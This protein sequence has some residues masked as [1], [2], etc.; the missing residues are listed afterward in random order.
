MAQVGTNA[1]QTRLSLRAE[2]S[3]P[4]FE[5]RR[6]AA[7]ELHELGDNSGVPVMIVAMTNLTN[8]TERNNAVVALRITKDPRSIPIL[9]KMTSDRSAYVRSIA[10][11]ALGELAATNAFD[12]I[13]S[14]LSDLENFGGDVPRCPGDSA[15]YAL[16]ALEDKKAI[17]LLVNALDHRETQ[18]QACQ[19]LEKLTGQ[20][21]RYDV[22]KWKTWWKEQQPNKTVQRTEAS[23]SARET[24]RTSSPAGSRR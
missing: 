20:P 18:T 2:L 22:E 6:R 9:T 13:A 14:H 3:S 12:A 4:E 24:N 5:T 7:I 8:Q 10:L 11:A 21:F 1:V 16:G 15:C 17:P 23:R 19:A